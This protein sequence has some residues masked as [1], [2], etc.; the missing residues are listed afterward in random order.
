[1]SIFEALLIIRAWF[2]E[3][4]GPAANW[5]PKL[6]LTVVML[7]FPLVTQGHVFFLSALLFSVLSFLRVLI[8]FYFFT[9]PLFFLGMFRGAKEKG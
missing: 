9:W 7:A 6:N 8:V 5:T 3:H 1:M 2:Y 4:I